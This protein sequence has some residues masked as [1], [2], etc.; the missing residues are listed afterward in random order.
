MIT[1]LTILNGWTIS[2]WMFGKKLIGEKPKPFY[3][4]IWN[5]FTYWSDTSDFN[6]DFHRCLWLHLAMA[7]KINPFLLCSFY[8]IQAQKKS[9][10]QHRFLPDFTIRKNDEVLKSLQSLNAQ[11]DSAVLQYILAPLEFSKVEVFVAYL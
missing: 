8:R 10:Q 7:L 6:L 1:Y 4:L 2:A 5:H 11:T 9:Y 3:L